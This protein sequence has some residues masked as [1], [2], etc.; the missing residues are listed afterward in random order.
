MFVKLTGLSA[1]IVLAISMISVPA[2][3]QKVEMKLPERE[4]KSQNIVRS[5]GSARTM[6]FARKKARD[7]WRQKVK[8]KFGRQ[9]TAWPHAKNPDY[10]CRKIAKGR[11]ICKIS[12]KPC[13]LTVV[14]HGPHKVCTFYKIQG[15]GTKARLKEWAKHKARKAWAKRVRS[16]YGNEFDTWL[17]S[18]NKETK[19][20]DF[21]DGTHKCSVISQPCN[22]NLIR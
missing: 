4:C 7:A 15:T 11:K 14:L 13:K 17:L 19:C 8:R 10:K 9:W 6:L 16:Y 18:N 2:I 5:G 1:G 22:F 21:D 3:A 20:E 12:A